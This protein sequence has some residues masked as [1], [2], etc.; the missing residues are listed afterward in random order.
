M[1]TT[2]RR[3]LCTPLRKNAS[4]ANFFVAFM[5]CL[6]VHLL[7]CLFPSLCLSPTLCLS[8]MSCRQ[9]LFVAHAAVAA[10]LA[11]QL[12]LQIPLCQLAAAILQIST[13][14]DCPD[15]AGEPRKPSKN[16]KKII[17]RF[18]NII[19]TQIT[20]KESDWSRCSLIFKQTFKQQ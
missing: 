4:T 17:F 19:I 1:G 18:I 5:M 13:K 6:S 14:F 12:T 8:V 3:S 9:T 2:G 20:S 10:T 16:A 11:M 15:K 7:Q